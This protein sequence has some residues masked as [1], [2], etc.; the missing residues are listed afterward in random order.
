M[1]TLLI[2]VP[3][4][5]VVNA[6]ATSYLMPLQPVVNATATSCQCHCTQTC[7]N[8][9]SSTGEPD[10]SEHAITVTLHK[11]ESKSDLTF[12][13]GLGT[14]QLTV[15]YRSILSTYCSMG[16]GFRFVTLPVYS[17]FVRACLQ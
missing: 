15:T 5:P 10:T 16:F 8:V 6:T 4:Q 9:C 1:G 11:V 14:D 13:S 3:L 2:A 17:G 12:G 7:I